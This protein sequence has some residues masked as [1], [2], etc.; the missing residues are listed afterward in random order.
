LTGIAIYGIGT[1]ASEKTTY[2]TFTSKGDS[3]KKILF[4]VSLILVVSPW[5]L[6]FA[7]DTGPGCGLG[8][9]IFPGNKKIV[10]Q[11]LAATTN[12]SFGNQTFG[13]STGTIGC[14]ND[15]LASRDHE[16]K[17]YAEANI[18]HLAQEMAQG[19]G[20]H[21]ASLA[22]L[23]G[24]PQER[25]EAFFRMTQERYTALFKSDRTT[26]VELLAAIQSELRSFPMS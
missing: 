7:D 11:V 13:I 21:L 16:L 6:A 24:I 23:L 9:M 14:T 12:G 2:N 10:P 8:T 18:E 1:K 25:Q 17:L 19:R 15:G 4:A 20:E 22:A 5:S 26:S 3:M